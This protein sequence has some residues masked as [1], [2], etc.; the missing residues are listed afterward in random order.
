MPTGEQR[1]L[2]VIIILE[3]KV[4]I[5]KMEFVWKCFALLQDLKGITRSIDG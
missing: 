3:H 5:T 4:L 2:C 1:E